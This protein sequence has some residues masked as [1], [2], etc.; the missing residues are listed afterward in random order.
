MVVGV[1]RRVRSLIRTVRFG[2]AAGL[3]TSIVFAQSGHQNISRPGDGGP[4]IK[5]EIHDPRA[6]AIDS[7]TLYIAENWNVIR[8]VDLS[9]G[10]ITTVQTKIALQAINCLAIDATGS[11]MAT[12]FTDDRVRKINPIDGSVVTIAAGQRRAAVDDEEPYAGLVRPEFVTQDVAG[13][14][15][16]VD[17]SRVRRLDAKTGVVTTVAGSGTKGTSGDG[18]PASRAALEFPNSVAIDAGGNLFI[19]QYGYGKDS[20]RIRRVDSRSGVITTIAGQ[21]RAGLTGDGGPALLAGL[22]SPSGL[23]FDKAGDL[24]VIDPVNH[25]IRR[26]DGRTQ[27]I[28]T[29]AGST[30]GF[31]GDGTSATSA[32]LDSPSAIAFDSHE[33]LYIADLANH[34]IRMVEAATGIISTVAGN[35]LPKTHASIIAT[36]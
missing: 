19:S 21:A 18:G 22:Q 16:I 11:I 23:L 12:E 25:R 8:R 6:I 36:R 10:T 7:T 32:Q 3:F 2:T 26:I 29:V 33:N 1:T 34:R 15:Y 20:H 9:S 27:T 4:A 30:K 35:G 17:M 5:A 31:A 14:L 13:N 28:S 24:Y